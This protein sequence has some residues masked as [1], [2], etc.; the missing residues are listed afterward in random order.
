MQSTVLREVWSLIHRHA[1]Q[2][3]AQQVNT[4]QEGS[5]NADTDRLVQRVLSSLAPECQMVFVMDLQHPGVPSYDTHAA[6]LYSLC[7]LRRAVASYPSQQWLC[8]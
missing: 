8:S 6:K 4:L 3:M 2:E 5:N 7:E 1:Q